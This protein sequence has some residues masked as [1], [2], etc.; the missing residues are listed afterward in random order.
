MTFLIPH[1]ATDKVM[2][3]GPTTPENPHLFL[4]EV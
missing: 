4:N 1:S 3:K 2:T